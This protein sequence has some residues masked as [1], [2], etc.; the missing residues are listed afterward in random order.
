MVEAF[1]EAGLEPVEQPVPGCDGANILAPLRGEQDRWVLVG[2]H[3]DH[4]GHVGGHTYHGADDNA[5]AV[6]IL[7]EVAR[8][9][10]RSPP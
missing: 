10:R 9:L 4:L 3:Y 2:A 5:A 8:A 7:L 6:A 1:R